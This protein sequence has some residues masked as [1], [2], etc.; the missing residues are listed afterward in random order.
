[1]K[2]VTKK[3]EVDVLSF[4]FGVWK[5]PIETM[6][7]RLLSTKVR[8]RSFVYT[9]KKD[10][11]LMVCV[12]TYKVASSTLQRFVL[13]DLDEKVELKTV[14][15]EPVQYQ[16]KPHKWIKMKGEAI[17]DL[18]VAIPSSGEGELNRMKVLKL[19]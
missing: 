14:R 12:R 3:E 6:D 17:L 18:S 11:Y 10:L 7:R 8:K 2:F 19:S 15:P 5:A 9:A 13:K 1:M 4:Y 16:E